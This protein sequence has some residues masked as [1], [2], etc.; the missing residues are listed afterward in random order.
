MVIRSLHRLAVP[1]LF[2]ALLAGCALSPTHVTG[3]APSRPFDMTPVNP[4]QAAQMISAYRQS[5]GL[6][7]VAVDARLNALAQE[8][9]NAMAR[10]GKVSHDLGGGFSRRMAGFNP[11]AAAENLGGGFHDLPEAMQRWRDSP[12]HNR[13]LLN[14]DVTLIGI[15]SVYAPNTTYKSY[16]ALVLAKPYTPPPGG[17]RGGP[18]LG[19]ATTVTIG[20]R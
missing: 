8:Q 13:N 17:M 19:P 7:P 18:P 10:T 2:G 4:E 12:G 16:W 5:Q 15:A 14:R 11:D 9:A 20:G 1:V 6:G 3:T